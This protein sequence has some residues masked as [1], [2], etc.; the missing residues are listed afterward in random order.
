MNWYWL[1]FVDKGKFQGGCYVEADPSFATDDPP[2][3]VKGAGSMPITCAIR[4][5]HFLGIN[6]G[7][8]V[9]AIGPGPAPPTELRD[10]LLSKK[11]LK[12]IGGFVKADGSD[13]R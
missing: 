13:I 2:G 1:S 10:R 9:A 12:K 7:G 11:D 6:P 8:Q 3:M 4:R 5:A